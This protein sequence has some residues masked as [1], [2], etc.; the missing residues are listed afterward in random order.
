MKTKK[1]TAMPE[2]EFSA[3]GFGCWA[4]GGSDIWNNTTNEDSIKAIHR[5]LDLGVNFFDV[6]P[7]YGFGHA[8]KILGQALKGQHHKV[9]IATKCGGLG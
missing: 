8:E 2:E 4:I 9:L 1:V 5:A 3:V 7:V 6:A